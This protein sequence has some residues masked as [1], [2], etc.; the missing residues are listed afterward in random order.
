MWT[1]CSKYDLQRS[2][3]RSRAM[4]LKC[5]GRLQKQDVNSLLRIILDNTGGNETGKARDL[6]VD[7]CRSYLEHSV[8]IWVVDF[9]RYMLW[10]F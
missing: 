5:Y 7:L 4:K 6:L 3:R 2:T 8:H 9:Q 1:E 10:F